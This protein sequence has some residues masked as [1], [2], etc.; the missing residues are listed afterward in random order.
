MMNRNKNT[1]IQSE[2]LLELL[3]DAI[4]RHRRK[5]QSQS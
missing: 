3:A 5:E 4:L 2:V 1:D